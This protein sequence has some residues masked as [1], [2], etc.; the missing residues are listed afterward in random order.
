MY[1]PNILIHSECFRKNNDRQWVNNAENIWCQNDPTNNLNF[2]NG[3]RIFLLQ[4]I[5]RKINFNR[6]P[7]IFAFPELFCIC[8]QEIEIL[9]KLRCSKTLQSSEHCTLNLNDPATEII[10]HRLDIFID[11]GWYSE[12]NEHSNAE[13]FVKFGENIY[14]DKRLTKDSK[15]ISHIH[16]T[17]EAVRNSFILVELGTGKWMQTVSELFRYAIS[18]HSWIFR[19]KIQHRFSI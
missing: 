17:G 8:G 19:F 6:K 14:N 15:K 18:C 16:S 12:E 2:K 10:V 7:I 4:R 5:N 11:S 13:V 1:E 3:L 9:K